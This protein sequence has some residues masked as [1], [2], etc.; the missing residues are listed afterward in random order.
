MRRLK[1]VGN[2]GLEGLTRELTRAVERGVMRGSE[3]AA[4]RVGRRGALPPML[5]VLIT[6]ASLVAAS[7]VA[8]FIYSTTRSATQQPIVQVT[9]AYTDGKKVVFTVRNI[10]NIRLSGL[11]IDAESS[12]CTTSTGAQANVRPGGCKPNT[13]DPGG[14][15]ACTITVDRALDDGSRCVV[16]LTAGDQ[17]ISLGFKVVR[18]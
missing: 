15:V 3:R 13:L 9:E 2:L 4:R 17:S 11:T 10:G 7:L 14:S 5:V 8:Y 12:S 6:V 16:H 18:P 1:P